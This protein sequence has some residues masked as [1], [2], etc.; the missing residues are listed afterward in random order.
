[1][2]LFFV[3]LLCFFFVVFPSMC[4]QMLS[5][6]QQ[7]E[8]PAIEICPSSNAITLG[9]STIADHPHMQNWIDAD[10]PISFNT[11]DRG[12]F[13]TSLTQ[14][15]LKVMDATTLDLAQVAGIVGTFVCF[16]QT[17]RTFFSLNYQ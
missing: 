1:M 14:E 3:L 2:N 12:I 9:L 13:H 10:Y 8:A 17:M 11:D 6:D 5:L 16:F 15:L 4:R 7:G